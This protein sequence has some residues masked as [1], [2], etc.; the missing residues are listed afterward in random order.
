MSASLAGLEHRLADS[1]VWS[2]P[3]AAGRTPRSWP[4]WPT[5]RWAAPRF[6]APPHF[7][8]PWPAARRTTAGPWRRV[9]PAVG[10]RAHRRDGRSRLRGQRLRPLRPLQERTDAGARPVGRRGAGHRGARGERERP[11]RPPAR[12][13][14]RGR[15]G[16]GLPARR[17]RVHQGRHPRLV[18]PAGPAYWDKPAPACLASRLP[19][20][21][22]VTLGRLSA[23]ERAEAALH[24]LG[25]RSAPG[26][27]SRRGCAH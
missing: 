18:T 27:S 23:V 12:A 7:P 20:G 10:R 4:R 19:Y 25:L 1:A 2:W 3:S 26:P 5:T 8:R 6:S 9:G 15:S 11:G 22:P 21:T 17:G 24:A 13:G 14:G 16:C